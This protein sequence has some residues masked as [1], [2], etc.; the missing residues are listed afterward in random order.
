MHVVIMC[1]MH[2]IVYY[3]GMATEANPGKLQLP[4]SR[5]VAARVPPYLTHEPRASAKPR[6]MD[7]HIKL[8]DGS[9]RLV[10]VRMEG[11]H[12]VGS[13]PSL[14]SRRAIVS[15][16]GPLYYSMH[17]QIERLLACLLSVRA[18]FHHSPP[19]ASAGA[20]QRHG[21]RRGASGRLAER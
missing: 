19:P 4:A 6:E 11:G 21:C 12:A 17:H 14:G 15:C 7:L 2:V 3:A 20:A 8:A 18:S 16:S 10:T 13:D 9:D 5:L 1:I